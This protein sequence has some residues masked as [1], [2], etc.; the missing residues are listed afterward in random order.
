MLK[1]ALILK[2]TS[3]SVKEPLSA[4][5]EKIDG[6]NE[7]HILRPTFLPASLPNLRGNLS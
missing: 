3:I 4:S 1:I 5:A 6:S 2:F 7:M